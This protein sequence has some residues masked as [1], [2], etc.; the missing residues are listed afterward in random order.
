[1]LLRAIA[2]R[3]A[4]LHGMEFVPGLDL[5]RGQHHRCAMTNIVERDLLDTGRDIVEVCVDKGALS[6]NGIHGHVCRQLKGLQ[7]HR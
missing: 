4:S 2:H 3:E 1:M 6:I 7:L 5:R